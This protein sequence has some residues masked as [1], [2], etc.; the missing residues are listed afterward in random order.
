MKKLLMLVAALVLLAGCQDAVKPV[1]QAKP[2]VPKPAD[3]LTG[4]FG[5]YKMVVPAHTWARDAQP[6]SGIAG[7]QRFNR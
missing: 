4:R 2:N 3:L 7:Q 1:E 6:F 5:F